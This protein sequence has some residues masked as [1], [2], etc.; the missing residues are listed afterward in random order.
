MKWQVKGETRG[1]AVGLTASTSPVRGLFRPV[2]GLVRSR[3]WVG[4]CPSVD[5][6]AQKF[7]VHGHIADGGGPENAPRTL[8][9]LVSGLGPGQER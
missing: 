3:P 7:G 1:L 5:A 4:P 2:R 6:W 9:V 8:S